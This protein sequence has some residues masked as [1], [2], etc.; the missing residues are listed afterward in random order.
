MENTVK[1]IGE[2]RVDGVTETILKERL[3]GRYEGLLTAR[4]IIENNKDMKIV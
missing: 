1:E 3:N 4:Q 2:L